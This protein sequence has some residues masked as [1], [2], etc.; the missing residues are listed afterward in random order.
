MKTKSGLRIFSLAVFLTAL[1]MLSPPPIAAKRVVLIASGGPTGTGKDLRVQMVAEA[2]RRANQDWVISV[3]NGFTGVAEVNMMREEKIHFT[4][5]DAGELK[6]AEKGHFFGHKMSKPVAIRW[7]LPSTAMTCTLIMI[8]KVPFNSYRE[9]KEKKY[10]FKFSMGRKKT[11]PYFINEKVMKAYGYSPEDILSWGG[12]RQNTATRRSAELISDGLME[13]MF[14]TG[15]FPNPAM[16]ELSRKRKLK[17]AF[18]SEPEIQAKL[19]EE[20]DFIIVPIKTVSGA[21]F[22]KEDTTTVAMP[23]VI[24]GPASLED[25]VAYNMARGVWEQ[26][27]K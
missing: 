21:S 12:K 15:T 7:I 18:V 6:N 20:E 16:V 11:D 2:M 26:R 8:E 10:P 25:D 9:F 3:L 14:Q 22:V 27:E 24:A 23:G 4:A 13:G 17:T 5:L 19:E 1:L